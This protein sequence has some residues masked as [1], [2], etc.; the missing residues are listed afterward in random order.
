MGES[1]S[2]SEKEGLWGRPVEALCLIHLT[3]DQSGGCALILN[4]KIRNKGSVGDLF[5]HGESRIL[6]ED[7]ALCYQ[8]QTSAL[9]RRASIYRLT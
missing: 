1:M 2:D 3:Y 8:V 7:Y 6:G 9:F 4:Y 5:M